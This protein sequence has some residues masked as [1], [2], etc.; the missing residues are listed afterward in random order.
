V[1]LKL[2]GIDEM[3]RSNY[4][5]WILPDE[6]VFS[7]AQ[8]TEIGNFS[9]DTVIFAGKDQLRCLTARELLACGSDTLTW[10]RSAAV[11]RTE[12]WQRVVHLLAEFPYVLVEDG[13]GNPIGYLTSSD[14][15]T[16]LSDQYN[17]LEAAFTAMV[18][19]VDTPVTMIDRDAR[20]LV[21]TK[22]AERIFAIKSRDIVGKPITNHFH[23]DMLEL[24]KTLQSGESV[25]NK[26]H[27]PRPDLYVLI[28]TNPIV[29]N[30]QIVGSVCTE[31]DITSQ[32]RLNQELA[33]ATA[34][35]H[36]LQQQ[37][38]QLR[39]SEDPFHE[40]KGTS[41]VIQHTIEISRKVGSTKATVLILGES[42]VGKELFAKGIHDV[43]EKQNAPFIAINCGAIPPSLFESELFG[44]EKG[45]FSGADQN[46][47]KGKIELARGGTLFLDEIGEMPLDMQVKLLRV[48]QERKYYPV[49]GTKQLNAD[50]RVIAATNRDLEEQVRKGLFRE[51]LYYRLNVVTLEIPPLRERKEDV[52]ELS[53]YFLQEFTLSY[54]RYIERIPQEVMLDLMHY[55][56]PGNIRELRNTIERLVV[57]S[58]EGEVK[59]EYL[60]GS[61][62]AKR[63]AEGAPSADVAAAGNEADDA[64]PD[65]IQ[66][67]QHELDIYERKIILRVL[68][69][70]KGNK[71]AAAKRLGMSR[72]T[73]YNKMNKLGMP[74]F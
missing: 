30:G 35:V 60:P 65:V 4:V 47:K 58:T 54:N 49:G 32:F 28:N 37:M 27:Q 62:R 68:A 56:W 8:L 41:A 33:D 25:V 53:Q 70:E 36:H 13:P 64:E 52:I 40:I 11:D 34:K 10:R 46:G 59:R 29:I 48:L 74:D 22:G 63:H 17:F 55:D 3:T 21:W 72:A 44:Y 39:R 1:H 19:T 45:A 73:L 57:F 38:A 69:L 20:T 51:D 66:T 61:I 16:C 43:R 24:L 14:A 18:D 9:L 6:G 26:L 50:F 2:P 5:Y 7:Q 23:P 42:G 71:Q 31:T 12:S 15:L 67:L